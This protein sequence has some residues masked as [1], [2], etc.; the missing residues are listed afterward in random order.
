MLLLLL[1][2]KQANNLSYRDLLT[3]LLGLQLNLLTFSPSLSDAAVDPFIFVNVIVRIG[4]LSTTASPLRSNIFPRGTGLLIVEFSFS[5][6]H[7]YIPHHEQFVRI[8]ALQ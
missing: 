4:S 7:F 8:Q 1:Y 5:Q 6:L 3:Y 2:V